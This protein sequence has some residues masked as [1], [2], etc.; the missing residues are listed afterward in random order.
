M[1]NLLVIENFLIFLI[2]LLGNFT[3]LISLTNLK[4]KKVKINI[5]YEVKK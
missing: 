1:K 2:V 5:R 3:F 4:N